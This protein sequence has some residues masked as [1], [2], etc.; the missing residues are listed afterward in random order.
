MTIVEVERHGLVAIGEGDHPAAYQAAEWLRSSRPAVGTV[1]NPVR[2]HVEVL[3]RFGGLAPRALVG[4]Q[5]VPGQGNQTQFTVAVA[6]FG[7]FDADDEP[8]C[9]SELWKEP[10]TVGLP[11]EFARAVADALGEGPGVPAGTL[12]ID[13]A[14]FDLVNSSEMIF[15]QA[16]AALKTAMVAQLSGQDAD[17]AT[18]TL[19]NTW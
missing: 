19:V 16:A 9:P 8:T 17:A 6:T 7:L 13:R 3:R 1:A 11:S 18:R 14:G 15:G 5:F 4:G 2:M 12:T 10:F